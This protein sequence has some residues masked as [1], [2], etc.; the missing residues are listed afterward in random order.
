MARKIIAGNID[1]PPFSESIYCRLGWRALEDIVVG[2]SRLE[3][4]FQYLNPSSD[5]SGIGS[6][7]LGGDIETYIKEEIK[8]AQKTKGEDTCFYNSLSAEDKEKCSALHENTQEKSAIY[9]NA[10]RTGSTESLAIDATI[11]DDA[12]IE[13]KYY[14]LVQYSIHVGVIFLGVVNSLKEQSPDKKGD[15]DFFLKQERAR[16]ESLREVET[17]LFDA[18]TDAEQSCYQELHA[19]L[20]LKIDEH[21][22][23]LHIDSPKMD[24]AKLRLLQDSLRVAIERVALDPLSFSDKAE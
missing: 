8:R 4:L 5:A 17:I 9:L 11:S 21:S 13:S 14:N 18:L 19:D 24:R 1:T 22:Q 10:L 2:Y 16:M 3:I 23:T 12:S 20:I 6:E 15:Y 7:D